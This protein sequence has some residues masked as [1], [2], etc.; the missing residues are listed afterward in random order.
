MSLVTPPIPHDISKLLA[1]LRHAWSIISLRLDDIGIKPT[2]FLQHSSSNVDCSFLIKLSPLVN[3]LA[4]FLLASDLWN[5]FLIWVSFFYFV[6]LQRPTSSVFLRVGSRLIQR[7]SGC[8]S[9][10][11]EW[12]LPHRDKPLRMRVSG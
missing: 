10:H 9:T 12:V 3:E 4:G 11:L 5:I 1:F 7:P 2:T 6:R 8:T